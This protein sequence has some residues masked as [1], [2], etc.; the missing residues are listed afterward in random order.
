[1]VKRQGAVSLTLATPK[2]K[3][4][5]Y[6]HR[7]NQK[8]NGMVGHAAGDPNVSLPKMALHGAARQPTVVN[9]GNR[10]EHRTLPL[11]KMADELYD[12]EYLTGKI[13]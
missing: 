10:G 12:S 7:G 1:M 11:P 2:T 4:A 8:K 9:S 13:D 5:V 3:C 6:I